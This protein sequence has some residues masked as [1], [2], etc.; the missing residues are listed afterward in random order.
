MSVMKV[1]SNGS[2]VS[3]TPTQFGPIIRIPYLSTRPLSDA[4]NAAPSGPASLKPPVTTM[5]ALRPRCP[6]SSNAC[7]T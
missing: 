4:S 3:I 6:H 5:T 2:A 1:V 7:G